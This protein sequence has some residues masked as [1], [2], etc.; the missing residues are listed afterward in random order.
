MIPSCDKV[1]GHEAKSFFVQQIS[2][3]IPFCHKT[4]NL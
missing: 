4:E 1:L 2:M 3:K